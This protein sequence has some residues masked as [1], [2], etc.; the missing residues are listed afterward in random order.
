M[1]LFSALAVSLVIVGSSKM[2]AQEFAPEGRGLLPRQAITTLQGPTPANV[3][4]PDAS[5][6]C[7]SR[8]VFATD[9][10]RNF[11]LT[12]RDFSF[13]PD[14][15]PHTLTLLSGAFVHLLS[16]E[17]EVS[18]AMQRTAL[19]RLARTAVSAGTRIEVVNSGKYP[20][21][22]RALIVEAK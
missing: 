11:K 17:G 14:R 16:G 10:D 4:T 1:R 7:L 15:Q 22:I 21:V 6:G 3:F 8:T 19:T 20:V 13:P 18:I 2:L 5:C 9:Q 12:I